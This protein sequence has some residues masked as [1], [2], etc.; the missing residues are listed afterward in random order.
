M[1]IGV[2]HHGCG[3]MALRPGSGQGAV[4]PSVPRDTALFRFTGRLWLVAGATILISS[5]TVPYWE[6][7]HQG[8]GVL[9]A[10]YYLP[11]ADYQTT[12]E[13]VGCQVAHANGTY[14]GAERMLVGTTW[15]LAVVSGSLSAL[16]TGLL[17]FLR[18][19]GRWLSLARASLIVATSAAAVI[20]A[21]VYTLQPWAYSLQDVFNDCGSVPNPSTTFSG[22]C[23]AGYISWGP[24]IGWYLSIAAAVALAFGCVIEWLRSRPLVGDLLRTT[25]AANEL[26]CPEDSVVP[27]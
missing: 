21:M 27:P 2:Q 22:S 12:C 4:F 7:V 1:D 17:T 5:L 19:R 14:T 20:P 26:H 13:V 3:A 8:P 25:D 16:C 24:G 18:R 15:G 23:Q 9:V 6:E 10:V 11:G